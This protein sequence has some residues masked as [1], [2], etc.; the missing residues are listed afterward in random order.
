[1][2]HFSPAKPLKSV[3]EQSSQ[4]SRES[5][6]TYKEKMYSLTRN[7]NK[8]IKCRDAI[9]QKQNEQIVSQV[10]AINKFERMESQVSK[11][12]AELGR[13]NHRASYWKSK[14]QGL[15]EGNTGKTKDLHHEIGLLKDKISSLDLENAEMNQELQDILSCEEIST[16]EGGKYTDSVR[17]CV[18]ELLSL[19]VGV[20]NIAPT[21]RCVIKNLTQTSV[22]RL[23]SHGLTCQMIVESLAAVQA[24]LG[25]KLSQT[26]MFSTLQSDGTTKFGK[27]YV[28]FDMRVCDS[29]A[30]ATTYTFGLRHVFSGAAKDTLETFKE[31]LSDLDSVQ[32]ALGKGSL[33][34][35][36]VSKI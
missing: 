4:I 14:V 1:M 9:I 15:K 34:A 19:N 28:A 5:D 26:E 2:L 7:A 29:E 3:A 31:I 12:K 16:F 30:K 27:H 8:K 22:G 13:V 33:S 35:V 32:L 20:K 23:P 10:K 21:I 11:L 17:A 24:Q 25:E 36:I 6:R 18:Y